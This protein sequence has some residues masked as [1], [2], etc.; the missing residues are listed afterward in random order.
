MGSSPLKS[1]MFGKHE[2]DADDDDKVWKRRRKPATS[3]AT[4]LFRDVMSKHDGSCFV[5]AASC[6]HLAR[7]MGYKYLAYTWP[8]RSWNLLGCPC[9]VMFQVVSAR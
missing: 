8:F 3:N 6:M 5:H 2:H 7:A 9:Q 1:D 4:I